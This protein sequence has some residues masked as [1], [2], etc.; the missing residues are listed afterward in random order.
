MKKLSEETP[1]R[2][3][4]EAQKIIERLAKDNAGL[5]KWFTG[6]QLIGML[7]IKARSLELKENPEAQPK[8]E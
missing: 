3:R 4:A 8:D 5:L 7:L 2:L 1:E 6:A